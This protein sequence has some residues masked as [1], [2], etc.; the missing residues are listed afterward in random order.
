M[1]IRMNVLFVAVGIFLFIYAVLAIDATAM[2]IVSEIKDTKAAEAHAK[3]TTKYHSMIATA[4]C[5]TGKTA[6]ET[7][8]RPGIAASRREWFGKTAR[9]YWNNNGE[10][11]DLIGEYVIEDTGGEPIRNGSVIDIWLP[12][13]DECMEFGRRL[14]LVEVSEE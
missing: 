1:T 5:L 7:D 11:G 9:V 3:M 2:E 12:T 4:Y 13:Y 10:P 6:T 8:T 14:V